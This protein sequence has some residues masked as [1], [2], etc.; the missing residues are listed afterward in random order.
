MQMYTQL[1]NTSTDTTQENTFTEL[2]SIERGY[3]SRLEDIY[4]NMTFP[5]VW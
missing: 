1:A 3:K 4:T 5:E 2:A